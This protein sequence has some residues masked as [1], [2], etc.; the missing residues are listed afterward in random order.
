MK[1]VFINK[2]CEEE[3]PIV[4][5]KEHLSKIL[6]EILGMKTVYYSTHNIKL[7]NPKKLADKGIYFFLLWY[8][9]I[10]LHYYSGGFMNIKVIL[11]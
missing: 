4:F 11:F 6:G 5:Y 10:E 9:C 2:F 7:V 3:P 8:T 1:T